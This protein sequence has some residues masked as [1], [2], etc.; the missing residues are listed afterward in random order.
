MGK[1][2]TMTITISAQDTI[3]GISGII[4][5]DITSNTLATVISGTFPTAATE[6]GAWTFVQ[7]VT[8]DQGM[9]REEILIQDLAGNIRTV[10]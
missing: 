2:N 5:R 1:E 9:H 10:T 8:G 7:E 3:L 6:I 4:V